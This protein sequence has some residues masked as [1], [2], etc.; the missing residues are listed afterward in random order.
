MHELGMKASSMRPHPPH[1]APHQAP[2]PL[3]PP[4][5]GPPGGP[6]SGG[7]GGVPGSGNGNEAPMLATIK[8]EGSNDLMVPGQTHLGSP[9]TGV[10]PYVDSTTYPGSRVTPPE[11]NN[12]LFALQEELLNGNCGNCNSFSSLLI[13][14][15]CGFYRIVSGYCT[16]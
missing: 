3:M 4:V 15:V 12:D 13:N 1:P 2:G 6:T 9:D 11:S 10:P 8:Q 7:P 14:L 16:S 5:S